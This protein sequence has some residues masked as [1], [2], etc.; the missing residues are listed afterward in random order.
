VATAEK[1]TSRSE[2][3]QAPAAPSISQP[4]GG[5]AISGIGAANPVTGT[6]SLSIPLAISPGCPGFDPLLSPSYDSGSDHG[7]FGLSLPAITRRTDKGLLQHR[8]A[9]E[10]D[11]FV[12]FLE[13]RWRRVS[14]LR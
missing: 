10:S 4:K 13:E 11:G 1:A 14:W 6:G 12:F 2:G 5:G 7:P 8:D 3:E 9:E